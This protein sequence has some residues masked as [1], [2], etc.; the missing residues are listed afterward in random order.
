MGKANHVA[1]ELYARAA[2][3]RS[4]RLR[5]FTALTLDPRTWKSDLERRFVE[6]LNARLFCGYPRLSY[7]EAVRN[8]ALPPNIEVNEFFLLAG[9]WL[10]APL[11]QQNYLSANYTDAA[12]YL[13]DRG[14]NVIAQLVSRQR[15]GADAPLSLAC[16]PDI[17][18]D[19][20][21]LLAQKRKRGEAAILVGQVNSELP[22]M[23]WDAAL[24][25][26]AFDHILEADAYDFPLFGVPRLPVSDAQYAIG[27]R[28]AALIPDGG[29]LQIGIGSIGDRRSLWP[30]S[31]PGTQ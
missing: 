30:L 20:L 11:A 15:P 19:V 27:L 17:T 24:P 2:A 23:G 28:C 4:I 1:N 10:A 31:A 29:T 12:K 3:D 13:M 14:L 22:Y 21:P 6:P 7:V 8:N 5:I 16:N 9:E 18:L 25:V 26:T